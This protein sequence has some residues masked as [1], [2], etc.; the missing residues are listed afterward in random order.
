MK[1]REATE[2]YNSPFQFSLARSERNFEGAYK[3][4][5]CFQFSL[6]RSENFLFHWNIVVAVFQFSLARSDV[7]S[8]AYGHPQFSSFQFSLA[9]S[10][11]EE[12]R[13]GSQTSIL[14]ILSCE[15]SGNINSYEIFQ[16]ILPF[17]SLLRDQLLNFGSCIPC[18]FSDFQF[19]LARSDSSKFS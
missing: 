18:F 11:V 17:N 1:M 7:M 16:P 6:A 8:Y 19:S 3:L 13:D 14:S 5:M 15:I 9:R 2:K 10:V 4:L 12:K